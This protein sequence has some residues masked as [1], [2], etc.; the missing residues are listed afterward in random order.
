MEVR[1]EAEVVGLDVRDGARFAAL[2]VRTGE[3]TVTVRAKSR[4]GRGRRLPVEPAPG[5]DEAW[6]P[7]A[8]QLPDPRRALRHGRRCSS[9]CS[10]TA[11]NRSAT[12][13]R[14]TWC[15]STRARRSSTAASSRASTASSL[16]HRR[17]PRTGER[18]LRRGR[19]LLAHALRHLGPPG[20]AA[21]RPDRATSFI[22]SKTLG[23]LHAAGVPAGQG[24]TRSRELARAARAAG[25]QA[26]IATVEEYN[27]AG[28]RR[29]LRPHHA[30]D[31]CRTEGLTPP[32][33]HWA[34]PHRHAALLRLPAAARRHL[35]LLRREDRRAGRGASSRAAGRPPTSSPPGR[36]W[37]A[38]SCGKGYIGGIG[39]VIGNVFGR[40]AGGE[41]AARATRRRA[42][43]AA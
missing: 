36:S 4:G 42:G 43:Q 19:G 38:T 23:P 33:T 22:D 8:R 26:C 2:T 7:A 18:Y 24:P 37:P 9:S 14:R 3:R 16:G 35:H 41:A 21:A 10:T 39:L 40:I 32:K 11:P 34:L 20:G 25:G 27:A 28:P 5:C 15:P 29:H 12:R 30:Q 31:D 17:Q 13:R 1:Y 6:G